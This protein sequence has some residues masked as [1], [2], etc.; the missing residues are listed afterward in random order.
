MSDVQDILDWLRS[1][2]IESSALRAIDDQFK[3]FEAE[4]ARLREALDNSRKFAELRKQASLE[5][6]DRYKKRYPG[7]DEW[8]K[9]MAASERCAAQEAQHIARHIRD[10]MTKLG[11]AHGVDEEAASAALEDKPDG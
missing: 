3:A 2:P 5:A 10:H 9:Y 8:S 11:M 1:C 7:E 4:N 6:A